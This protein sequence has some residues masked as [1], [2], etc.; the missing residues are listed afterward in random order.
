MITSMT[1]YV[2]R[3][4]EKAPFKKRGMFGHRKKNFG[5]TKKDEK[6]V[7]KWS[8]CTQHSLCFTDFASSGS[9]EPDYSCAISDLN[10]P[11]S[12]P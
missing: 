8:R 3:G 2:V 6:V 11:K 9:D 12:M 1:V 7:R 5:R 10:P 4:T